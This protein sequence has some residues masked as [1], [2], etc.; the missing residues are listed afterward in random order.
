MA[1]M[2]STE[3]QVPAAPTGRW[4]SKPRRRQQLSRVVREEHLV[5]KVLGG[6]AASAVRPYT[7]SKTVTANKEEGVGHPA[8]RVATTANS[9]W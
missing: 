4:G 7:I 9:S 3:P 1:P 2:G 8:A 5:G 6:M